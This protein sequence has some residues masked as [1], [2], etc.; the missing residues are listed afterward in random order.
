MRALFERIRKWR[1]LRGYKNNLP[2]LLATRYGRERFY[3]PAQVLSTIKEHRLSEPFAA[4]ACAMFCSKK[5][6][7][8]FAARRA[9]ET[10]APL[11]DGSAP[12]WLGMD[13]SYWPAHQDVVVELHHSFGDSLHWTPSTDHGGH[14]SHH[15]GDGF[16][17]D[18]FGDHG[19]GGLDHG[20]GG[21][22]HGGGGFDHGGHS[23]GDGGGGSGGDY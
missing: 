9:D 6:Y 20:G 19:G 23:G 22:D 13:L 10:F 1:A 2:Y 14:F 16:S 21:L 12:P 18:S 17:G 15:F 8:G 4:I 7:A 11:V 3:T 5:G